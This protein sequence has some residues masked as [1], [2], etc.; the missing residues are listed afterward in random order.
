MEGIKIVVVR[1]DP[2]QH[3]VQGLRR[4]GRRFLPVQVGSKRVSLGDQ[5]FGELFVEL[6]QRTGHPPQGIVDR[7]ADAQIGKH[8]QQ[9]LQAVLRNEILDDHRRFV[10]GVLQMQATLRLEKRTAECM[11]GREIVA[12]SHFTICGIH[13]LAPGGV[14]LALFVHGDAFAK[15]AG[16]LVVGFG[17]CYHV[18]QLVP[19]HR[20]PIGGRLA[21]GGGACG[22]DYRPEADAQVARPSRQAKRADC[23]ILLLGKN[24][25]DHFR[26]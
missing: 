25:H 12:E 18:A 17:E 8:L 19:Q 26:R 5:V 21:L 4:I 9:L 15:P 11:D 23:E 20:L 10:V 2:D 14:A 16:H 13:P 3:F 6:L 7:H 24:L 1:I 22:R